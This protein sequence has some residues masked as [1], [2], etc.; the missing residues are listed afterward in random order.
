MNPNCGSLNAHIQAHFATS[1]LVHDET[2]RLV[3]R[4][5]KDVQRRLWLKTAPVRQA[6]EALDVDPTNFEEA[7]RAYSCA[8]LFLA[9]SPDDPRGDS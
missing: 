3:R 2:R 9:A 8:S 1:F 7:F 4:V 6:L 5:L